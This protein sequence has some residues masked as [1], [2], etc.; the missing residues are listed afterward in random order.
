[1]RQ[2]ATTR[3]GVTLLIEL[4]NAAKQG[5]PLFQQMG[6]ATETMND[7]STMNVS[8]LNTV[9][10]TPF[11]D[12]QINGRSLNMTVQRI[13]RSRNRDDLLNSAIRHGASRTVMKLFANMSHKEFNKRRSELN[14]EDIRSRPSLLSDVEYDELATLHSRY[15]QK[16]PFNERLDHLR[17]LLYL[18]ER[19]ALDINRIYQY[20]YCEHQ[21]IFLT[22]DLR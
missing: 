13:L 16:H 19:M 7:L 12:Y 15:G 2:D 17:C 6:I 8:E 3:V 21:A 20:F 5:N 11:V 10:A 22:G 4:I 1:M 14:L 18:S 9:A